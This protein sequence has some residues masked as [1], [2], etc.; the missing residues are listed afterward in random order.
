VETK[1]LYYE[2]VSRVEFDAEVAERFDF[3]GAPAVVLDQTCF[4]PTSGG[5]PHDTGTL[6]DA[7]VVNV[8]AERGRVIHVLE[9]AVSGPEVHGKIDWARRFDH[10]QQ[11]TGQHM[12]SQGFYRKIGA[13]TVG[14]HLGEEISTIDL[15]V[16]SL[17]PEVADWVEEECNRV[18]FED[19]RISTRTV[20]RAEL[21]EYDLR[22]E[23]A[24]EDNIRLVMIEGFDTVACGGTHC[25]TTGQVGL[26][27]IRRWEKVRLGTRV[28]FFCGG[29]AL[30][31]YRWKNRMMLEVASSLTIKDRELKRAVQR[32][33]GENHDLRL[34]VN[35]LKKEAIAARA[36]KLVEGA[37]RVGSAVLI[38]EEPGDLDADECRLLARAITA[39][40]GVIAVL[41][42]EYPRPTI[43]AGRSEDLGL[44]LRDVFLNVQERV[45]GKGGGKDQ[46]VTMT[47][48]SVAGLREAAAAFRAEVGKRLE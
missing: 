9:K 17:S 23:P 6:N 4:Y 26:I 12:L 30:A 45:G 33:V 19:R 39:N 16:A 10:M 28:E 42:T 21:R 20:G 29:R 24:V 2:D 8:V 25:P 13:K 7:R 46:F 31:D 22:K 3:E 1:R 18:V 38:S 41:S 14:F 5:Q 36:R 37:S 35:K 34:Q 15:N 40:P 48:D 43:I 44:S 32:L 47:F 27:K 11:H